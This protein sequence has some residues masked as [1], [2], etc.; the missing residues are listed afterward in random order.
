MA[1]TR[2]PLI[3]NGIKF[4]V[5][6]LNLSIDK[7]L[8][9]QQLPTQA[10]IQYQVWYDSPEVLGIQGISAGETAFRELLFLK[11]NFENT[12]LSSPSELFYKTQTYKGFITNLTVGH[13]I[14]THLRFPYQI[15]FQL[16]HGE[17]FNIQDF[18]LEAPRGIIGAAS[19]FIEENINAP[20]A[21]AENALG[22]LFGKVI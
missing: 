16:L 22:K 14:D 10:G 21:R 9:Y 7:P 2:F 6:P 18:S 5:N 1:N 3:L 17:K 20:I 11:Q 4:Q 12:N 15:N 13:S 19:S 8:V